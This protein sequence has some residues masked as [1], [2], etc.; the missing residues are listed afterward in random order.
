[1]LV[2][3]PHEAAISAGIIAVEN[4]VIDLVEHALQARAGFDGL[5]GEVCILTGCHD[6]CGGEAE[7]V[8]IISSHPI[9]DFHIGTVERADG[10]RTIEGK[11]HI[12]GPGGFFAG[13]RN[14]F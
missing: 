8:E 6:L 14:L 11:F 1:M 3:P 7:Q 2:K 9:P 4:P 5:A 10:R 13:G 12:A